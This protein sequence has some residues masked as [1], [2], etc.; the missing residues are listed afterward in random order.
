MRI[1]YFVNRYP[2]ISHTFIRREI[3]ALEAHGVTVDRIA[4]RADPVER[5]VDAD[6][7]RELAKTEQLLGGG[8]SGLL[9]PLLRAFVGNPIRAT[10]VLLFALGLGRRTG[11]SPTKMLA[12]WAEALVLRARTAATGAELVRV[13][14]GTNGAIVARLAR[15]LGGAPYCVAYHGPDEFDAPER[16]DIAGIVAESA[17]VTAISS[18]CT[19][20]IMRWSDPA[21]WPRIREVRCIVDTDLFQ[22]TPIAGGALRLCTVA[23]IAPQKGLPLLLDALAALPDPP[24]LDIVGDGPGRPALEAQAQRLGLADRVRFLGARDGAGVRATLADASV[25][26]L[27]SFA[28]GLPVVIM[29]ALAAGRPVIASAIAA[30]GE[31]VDAQAGWLVPAGDVA[32]IATAIATAA[33]TDP[34]TLAAMGAH[35]RARVR[36]RHSADAA[37]RSLIDA[38]TDPMRAAASTA[39]CPV[40]P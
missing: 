3:E 29:E 24:T 34:A 5:L 1:A 11:L 7:R 36:E 4:L 39:L 14:F 35:G 20:Q 6:D 19:S 15:R 25:F 40:R 23:R 10:G 21:H 8:M 32:G 26:I 22:P 18:F 13:H 17:F 30:T 27:P 28:E 37:A 2:A 33:A 38:W 16:W 9:G 31:L 12:Y